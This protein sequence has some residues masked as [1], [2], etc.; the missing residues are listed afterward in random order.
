EN[1]KN[2]KNYANKIQQ[3]LAI[4]ETEYNLK[5]ILTHNALKAFMAFLVKY[6]PEILNVDISQAVG[7][8]LKRRERK[9]YE[10]ELGKYI[11]NYDKRTDI[12][13][14]ISEIHKF[15][16]NY[17]LEPYKADYSGLQ[18]KLEPLFD[19]LD[20]LELHK[21]KL[22]ILLG[23]TPNELQE[24][25]NEWKKDS[26]SS[27]YWLSNISS[28]KQW[29]SIQM[30]INNLRRFGLED[31][32]NKVQESDD[33]DKSVSLFQLFNKSF[34]NS[35]I[36]EGMR[37]FPNLANFNSKYHRQ[38]LEK[39]Q[40]LDKE[41]IKI[42]RYRLAKKLFKNR[43][44]QTI[45]SGGMKSSEY[46]ILTREMMKKRNVKPLRTILNITKHFVVKVKPCFLMSPLSVAK[47][48]DRKHF[49]RF[50]DVVIFDEAS[51]VT[52]EDAIGA[53]LRGKQLIVVGDEKQ[54]PP[55]SFF[56]SNIYDSMDDF[57][58][59]VDTFDSILEECT[60]I[61]LPSVML[62]YHYRSK[63]EGLIAFS[64]YH[65]YDNNLY[66]FP[67]LVRQ[68]VFESEKVE[69]LPA[70]EFHHIK[71][72]IYDKGGTRTNKNEAH[73]VASHIIDHYKNNEKNG[74]NFSLGVVAFSEAQ[75]NA[76][77]TELERMYK[78]D[79]EL[80]LLVHK[81]DEENNEPLLL[82]NLENIQ[83]D[84]RDF[85]FFSVGYGKDQEGDFSLNFGPINKTGGERRLNVAITRA[86]YHVKIFCS[87]LPHEIDISRTKSAGVHLLFDYLDFARLGM[88]AQEQDAEKS[89]GDVLQSQF[90]V[91]VQ[92]NLENRGYIV[93]RDVGN[94]KYLVDIAIVNP[95]DPNRYL[96]GIICDGGSYKLIPTARDRDR[97]RT[98]IL[99]SLG[100]EM[101]HIFSP[102]WM[103]NKERIL[104]Q[105]D[106]LIEEKLK[107]ME[108]VA[109]QEIKPITDED[110]EPVEESELSVEYKEKEDEQEEK[111]KKVDFSEPEFRKQLLAL[112]GVV[113]YKIYDKENVIEE[114]YF[115]RETSR[116]KAAREIIEVEGPIH[117]DL[118]Y[119]RIRHYFGISYMSQHYTDLIERLRDTIP[120]EGNFYFP[121]KYDGDLIR[122]EIERH[123]DPRKFDHISDL[124]LENAME[125]FL[126]STLSMEK[127]ELFKK[128]LKL[129]GFRGRRK[130]YLPRLNRILEKLYADGMF[131]HQK[132][133][134]FTLE[135]ENLDL[136][137]MYPE[138]EDIPE[139]P[140]IEEHFEEKIDIDE[141]VE[142]AHA[143]DPIEAV[144]ETEAGKITSVELLDV[145]SNGLSYTFEELIEEF[146]LVEEAQKRELGKMIT[147]LVRAKKIITTIE[148]GKDA[149]KLI[150][151]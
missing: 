47:F 97:V 94:S 30:V 82:K 148:D 1:L 32:I 23:N 71:N 6:H 134:G 26:E 7:E 76:I 100:W 57:A 127:G 58:A 104:K 70:I 69:E 72:G 114:K 11:R 55:T 95:D 73:E 111:E 110:L 36:Q 14:Y 119:D 65:F 142:E 28:L 130:E 51:Q 68:G 137:K 17:L 18:A 37:K 10:K 117:W 9:H 126:N 27:D 43:P 121:D 138:P 136:D 16:D 80:E 20:K 91:A 60:G 29:L 140:K 105:I 99:Q 92:K 63:K 101:I 118:L 49:L 135:K 38:I 78:E 96:L 93:E 90:E 144:I 87:F 125:L 122:I 35:W 133:R 123:A 31:F 120:C 5:P 39:F 61:G 40:K 34:L 81:F 19:M 132:V 75:R 124:E 12:S 149:W 109:E 48:L 98:E 151:A 112:P 54:L 8:N 85:I 128:A 150:D 52:P 103:D 24:S 67:D 44:K 77:Y 84:E 74:T 147:K 50:F 115:E 79:P 2:I 102:E 64:N 13:K 42:N 86:R 22:R 106:S 145:L 116:Q 62:N 88:F 83:G 45:L 59:D 146:E 15:K 143:M 141:L 3:P 25:T 131:Q 129:F 4:V 46:N 21:A 139:P 53:I 108:E 33:I 41:I 113:R 89:A 107:S 56:H 66:T